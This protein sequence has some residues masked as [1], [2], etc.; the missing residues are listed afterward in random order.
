MKKLYLLLL[1]LAFLLPTMAEEHKERV[2][3][4]DPTGA[5]IDEGTRIAVR[6]IIS[7]TIVNSGKYNIVERSMLEKVMQEQSFSNSGAVDDTQATEI[8]KLA[9][10]SKVVISILT[11][12]GKR[13][14]LSIKMIDVKTANVEKQ[15]I[16]VISSGELLDI[17]EPIT[18]ELIGAKLVIETPQEQVKYTPV[19]TQPVPEPTQPKEKEKSNLTYKKGYKGFVDFGGS[20]GVFDYD[21][22][23]SV[24]VFTSHG[25]QCSSYFFIGAGLGL[26]YIYDWSDGYPV[27]L[28]LFA[29]MRVNLRNP[30]YKKNTPYLGLR[31]GVDLANITP[32][33]NLFWGYRWPRK[34]T[35]LNL[36]VGYE[37]RLRY[38]DE[39]YYSG[40]Y[41]YYGDYYG[42]YSYSTS[43]AEFSHSLSIRFGIEF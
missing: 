4:F 29:E 18:L 36:N 24:G 11:T 28:P 3:V 34:S 32:Y 42:G 27:E 22:A 7:S 25:Y 1:T 43:Y 5:N 19:A 12:T 41:D 21:I 8:G 17:A 30:N 35:A 2:A 10:A 23:A 37:L 9:G 13:M 38:Y 26:S 40:Y 16:K 6:E 14:I 15:K 20:L 39:Y 33:L 31:G